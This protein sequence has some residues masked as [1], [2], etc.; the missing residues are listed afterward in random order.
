MV[1]Q[2]YK[3]KSKLLENIEKYGFFM[4]FRSVLSGNKW[5]TT[6]ATPT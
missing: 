3:G 6:R 5:V 2:K 1:D 4:M